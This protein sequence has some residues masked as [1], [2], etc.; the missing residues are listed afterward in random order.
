MNTMYA[1]RTNNNKFLKEG[2]YTI[3]IGTRADMFRD[4]IDAELLLM[5]FLGN[6]ANERVRAEESLR[7]QETALT[8]ATNNIARLNTDLAELYES[9]YKDVYQLVAK[10]EKALKRAKDRVDYSKKRIRDN[11]AT[12]TRQNNK[13]ALKPEVVALAR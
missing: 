13:L 11:K 5:K 8:R 6:T 2:R 9:P 1:V 4:K 7:E 12:I 10:K 3:S